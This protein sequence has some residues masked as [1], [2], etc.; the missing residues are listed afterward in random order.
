MKL[1]CGLRVRR[2]RIYFCKSPSTSAGASLFLVS[3]PG[4]ENAAVP[5]TSRACPV[6]AAPR[7]PQPMASL[8]AVTPIL[9]CFLA[10]TSEVQAGQTM[11]PAPKQAPS[12]CRRLPTHLLLQ[13]SP[14][15]L[16][17]PLPPP[18]ATDSRKAKGLVLSAA[19]VALP[20]LQQILNRFALTPGV[21]RCTWCAQESQVV[22]MIPMGPRCL[23]SS[24]SLTT[25]M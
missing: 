22:L 6:P 15:V 20:T 25:A 9:F 10:P 3:S 18:A 7:L 4:E 19:A 14:P 12:P 23:H 16:P 8:L 21:M 5:G 24:H 13:P 11:S 2:C 1:M 17:G